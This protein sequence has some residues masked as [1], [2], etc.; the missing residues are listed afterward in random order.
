MEDWAA[1]IDNTKVENMT[2]INMKR[3][4]FVLQCGHLHRDISDWDR[5]GPIRT[6]AKRTVQKYFKKKIKNTNKV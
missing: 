4:A 2:R 1:P 5:L 3:C 6:L